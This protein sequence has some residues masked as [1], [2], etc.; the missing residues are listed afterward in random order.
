[1]T[2]QPELVTIDDV[3]RLMRIGFSQ[4]A[5][6]ELRASA[7]RVSL[8]RFRD[9]WEITIEPKHGTVTFMVPRAAITIAGEKS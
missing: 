1:M 8:K 9:Q 5:T 3:I 4:K 2:K 7:C 6:G